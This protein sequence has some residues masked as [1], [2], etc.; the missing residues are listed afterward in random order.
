M[1]LNYCSGEDGYAYYAKG[2]VPFDDFMT[3]IKAE[4]DETD[5]I[6]DE[7]PTH[8]WKRVARDFQEAHAVLIDAKPKARGAFPVTWISITE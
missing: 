1:D 5:A 8:A 7:L 6:R 4:T 2:H 3:Q